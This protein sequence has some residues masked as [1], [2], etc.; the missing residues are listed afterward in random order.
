MCEDALQKIE[1]DIA[2]MQSNVGI[3]PITGQPNQFILEQD[4][5]PELQTKFDK[6]E[7]EISL[8]ESNS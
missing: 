7:E 8:L 5:R 4:P 2:R 6:L 1:A 3:C